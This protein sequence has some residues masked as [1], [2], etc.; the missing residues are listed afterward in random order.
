M[1]TLILSGLASMPFIET[2][3]SRIF[4]FVIQSMHLCVLS[5]SLASHIF[6][7]VSTKLEM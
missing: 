4:P 7:K 5:F 1:R 2:K 6:V 3:K